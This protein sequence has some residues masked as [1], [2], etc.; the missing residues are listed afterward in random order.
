MIKVVVLWIVNELGEM[1]L[2]E[3]AHHKGADPGVWGPAVTGRV[4]LGEDF[5]QA[6]A[7]ETAEEL[8]L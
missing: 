7:R 8:A 6:L 3:R 4:E 2:A 5:D 1:L